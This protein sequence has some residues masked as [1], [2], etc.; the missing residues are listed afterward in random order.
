MNLFF[1]SLSGLRRH[2]LFRLARLIGVLLLIFI[3]L[4]S[5][6]AV[7]IDSKLHPGRFKIAQMQVQALPELS[8][9]EGARGHELMDNGEVQ[10]QTYR[11]FRNTYCGNN[12]HECSLWVTSE[13]GR[14]GFVSRSRSLDAKRRVWPE[15]PPHRAVAIIRIRQTFEGVEPSSPEHGFVDEHFKNTRMPLYVVHRN[16]IWKFVPGMKDAIRV[17]DSHWLQ[18]FACAK[19]LGLAYN[20][21]SEQC[22]L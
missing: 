19:R 17:R 18:E 12:T 11:L 7:A 14:Y 16:G 6:A 13:D 22:A 15:A 5:H 10:A 8:M 3:N 4:G 2:F 21:K 20:G 9:P 1:L